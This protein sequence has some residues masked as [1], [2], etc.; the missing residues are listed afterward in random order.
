MIHMNALFCLAQLLMAL[1]YSQAA[2]AETQ[3]TVMS[4]NTWGAGTNDGKDISETVAV[5][6]AANPDIIGLQEIR[7]ESEDCA[8]EHCPAG[9]ESVAPQLAAALGYYLLEQLTDN[10]LLWA[11]A[12]LSRYPIEKA[13]PGL[14]GARIRVG[15]QE[16]L[17]FNIHATDYP[18]GPFQLLKIPY[19]AAPFAD[20][21]EQAIASARAA[22]DGA[23]TLLQSDI[24]AAGP[25]DAIFIT[26]DFNEPSFRD[27]TPKAAAAGVHP[28]EVE[29]P[30]TRTLEDLG[31]VD[32]FRSAHSDPLSKPGF[33][34]SPNIKPDTLDDHKD[35]I[36]YIF[37]KAPGLQV[38]SAAIVGETST[39]SDIA[40]DPYPSDHRAVV[41]VVKF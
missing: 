25:A 7:P 29:W 23:M 30:F 15:D 26:G 22:R 9:P 32:L 16:V 34:W 13:T 38:L 3:L 12:I 18:Y 27:W 11:N 14:L 31:F 37:G 5:I 6:R 36:D 20:T 1:L 2:W 10:E 39:Y 33:T 21:A 28:L 17:L 4:F 19:G 24:A 8:A 41:A 35:R 40:V